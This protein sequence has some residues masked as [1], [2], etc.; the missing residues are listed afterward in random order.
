MDIYLCETV[1]L[2][3]GAQDNL[4]VLKIKKFAGVYP[5]SRQMLQYK[6]VLSVLF[7]IPKFA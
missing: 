4:D 3:L 1:L 6:S 2:A 7:R 5:H